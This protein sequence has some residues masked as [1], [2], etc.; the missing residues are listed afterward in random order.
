MSYTIKFTDPTKLENA[1]EVVDN[2][3][4]YGSTSLGIPGKN[5]TSYGQVIGENF[6]H[7]LENFAN[8]SAPDNPVEGQLWY[9]NN[10]KQLLVWD[11]TTW[12]AAGGL[13]KDASEPD[14]STSTV[15]D[16]W[17]N[18]DTQQLYLFTGSTWILVG[19]EFSDGLA[20][21]AVAKT[22]TGTDNQSYTVLICEINAKPAV[23]VATNEFTPKPVLPGYSTIKPGINISTLDITGQGNLTLNGVAESSKSLEIGKNKVEAANFLRGDTIST[24]SK[25]FRIRNNQGLQVGSSDNLSLIIDGED[26]VIG[27]NIAGAAINLRVNDSGNIGTALKIAS[28]KNVGIQNLAPDYPLDVNGIIKNNNVILNT[29]DQDSTSTTTGSIQTTGGVGIAK[30]IFA[31]QD[32]TVNGTTTL[33][34]NIVPASNSFNIGS[35]DN[36]VNH[37]YADKITSETIIGRFQGPLTGNVNGTA[38]KLASPTTFQISG[39]VASQ[40]INFDGAIGSST[41]TFNTTIDPSFISNKE[42]PE[43]DLLLDTD[44]FLINRPQ[45][46][47]GMLKVSKSSLL[48][49]IPRLPVGTIMPYVGDTAPNAR[50]FGGYWLLCDG[51]TYTEQDYPEL[52]AI[53]LNKF[54]PNAGQGEF[55]VPDL[56]GRLPLGRDNMGGTS[57]NRVENSAADT[58]GFSAGQETTTLTL[59]Q[60]PDHKHDFIEDNTGNSYYATRQTAETPPPGTASWSA[61]TGASTSALPNTG[62]V[63]DYGNTQSAID[64]MNPFL[65]INYIIWT[66]KEL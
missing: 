24:T 4:N 9:D 18:T 63:L 57:A 28:N 30:S 32:L 14:A 42:F 44:E 48:N 5:S 46:S 23:I 33:T 2:D 56:R 3:I 47:T 50:D 35:T 20:T 13:K 1:I 55:A 43:D 53:C 49:S 17:V 37:I 38:T 27:N 31:G 52:Y 7:L 29:F 59:N 58:T 19:P 51:T 21:G 34:G 36:K 39:D 11:S 65:T 60:I 25:L 10:I 61:P 16:L 6:L 45:N 12:V 22:L 41:K 62:G 40:E 26:A 66:G 15:G 54:D 64:L 8:S